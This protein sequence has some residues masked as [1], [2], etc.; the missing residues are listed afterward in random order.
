M[1]TKDLFFA[2]KNRVSSTGSFNTS[3]KV[4]KT[5]VDYKIE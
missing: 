3:K 2:D 5:E 4:M 1:K